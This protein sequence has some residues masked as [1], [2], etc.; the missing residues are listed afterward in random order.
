MNLP[1]AL[2]LTRIAL[3]PIF[4][5]LFTL[6]SFWSKLAA[7]LLF[8]VA[9]LTDFFDGYLA[10]RYN[11]QTGFGKFMDPLA[12]KILVSSAL[13]VFVALGFLDP[14]PVVLIVAR[15]FGIT[16]LRLLVAYRGQVIPPSWGGKTKT[17]LQMVI[18]SVGMAYLT[19]L[20]GFNAFDRP[21][22][23]IDPTLVDTI[24]AWLLW[25]TAA[26]TVATGI[27]YVVKYF[28]MIRSVL[29]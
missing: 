24:F 11:I 19:A 1:N 27:D 20:A 13:I 9:S 18:V 21:F 16:G 2:T 6:E 3:V 7:L 26:I 29:K 8:V 4:M 22:P 15:E 12:D 25:I 17:F 28:G 5:L 14:L 10:R 23:L